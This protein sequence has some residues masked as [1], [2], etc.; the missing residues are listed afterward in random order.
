VARL[1]SIEQWL[2]RQS[3]LTVFAS[4]TIQILA[5]LRR[6][7]FS[8]I[9]FAY[10]TDVAHCIR[11]LF[12]HFRWAGLEIIPEIIRETDNKNA[13]DRIRFRSPWR[14]P[15]FPGLVPKVECIDEACVQGKT[16]TDTQT[17]AKA[18]A[19]GLVVS[20]GSFCTCPQPCGLELGP[21]L[22]ACC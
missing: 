15:W 19:S 2:D 22:L 17:L 6:L 7:L 3:I 11:I 12:L 10:R 14:R 18:A 9:S 5:T 13:V 4:G 16:D 1:F 20:K 8:C 21:D